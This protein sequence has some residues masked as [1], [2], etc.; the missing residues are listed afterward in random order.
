MVHYCPLLMGKCD[1]FQIKKKIDHFHIVN[2]V[3]KFI[4]LDS[5]DF[6]SHFTVPGLKLL[7]KKKR[8]IQKS[9]KRAAQ[10]RKH[11]FHFFFALVNGFEW[12]SS[13]FKSDMLRLVIHISMETACRPP[14]LCRV[15]SEELLTAKT[16][17]F[18]HFKQ[19]MKYGLRLILCFY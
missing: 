16:H 18:G 9:S 14:A 8:I 7:I 13:I 19:W 5:F 1:F 15:R 3:K 11:I 2:V 12:K 17:L 6:L 4:D 10:C